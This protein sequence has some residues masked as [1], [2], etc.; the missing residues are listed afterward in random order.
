MVI[1]A[2]LQP[3]VL[4]SSVFAVTSLAYAVEAYP[5]PRSGFCPSGYHASGNYCVPN[6]SGTGAAIERDGFCPSGY[7][8]SGNY[9]VAN[10]SS[11]GKAIFRDGFCPSGYHASGKYCV[12]N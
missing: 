9:C 10:S 3:L 6:N 8:A 7:H 5:V 1:E 2:V 4:I 12:E 11:S